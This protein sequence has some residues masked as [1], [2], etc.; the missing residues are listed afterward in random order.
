MAKTKNHKSSS[1]GE[2]DIINRRTHKKRTINV[3]DKEIIIY[4]TVLSEFQL[5]S[6]VSASYDGNR[7]PIHD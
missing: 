4:N 1:V 5:L 6:S 3:N 2:V 7:E